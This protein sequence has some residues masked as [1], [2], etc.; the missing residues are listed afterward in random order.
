MNFKTG[1]GWVRR[2]I[3]PLPPGFERIE[4]RNIN[5]LV[6]KKEIV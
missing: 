5:D 1:T 4:E 6:N 2:K 3:P